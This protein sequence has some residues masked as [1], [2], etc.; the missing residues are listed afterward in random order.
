MTQEYKY[1]DDRTA[2]QIAAFVRHYTDTK[3]NVSKLTLFLNKAAKDG[4][5]LTLSREAIEDGIAINVEP[6]F[7]TPRLLDELEAHK[8]LAAT[9]E[10]KAKL[11]IDILNS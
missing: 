7:L 5:V 1:S 10:K 3:I 9:L 4:G 11:I 6:S 2:Y 8:A